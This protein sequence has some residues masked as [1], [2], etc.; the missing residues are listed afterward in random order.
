MPSSIASDFVI[1]IA[2]AFFAMFCGVC[3][4]LFANGMRLL[5]LP[6]NPGTRFLA[7]LALIV[8]LYAVVYTKTQEQ[9]LALM[10]AAF[11]LI[12]FGLRSG[13]EFALRG[14][15]TDISVRK[16]AAK[17]RTDVVV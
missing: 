1:I 10:I 17:Q 4:W 8:L 7:G 5:E 14:Y 9:S 2:L 3:G 6:K 11:A 13:M 15:E 16:P 12:G